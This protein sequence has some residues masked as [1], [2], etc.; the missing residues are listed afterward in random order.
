MGVMDFVKAGV[1]QMMIARP[2]DKKHLVVWKWPDQNIPMMS[3]LTVDSDEVAVFFKNGACMGI[4]PGGQRHTLSTQNIP[5]LTNLVNQFTG[6]NVLIAE[7]FFVKVQPVRG[8]PVGGPIGEM[9]DPLTQEVVCPRMF[10]EMS[11]QVVDPARFIIGYTGQAAAAEDNDV[12]LDWVKGLF[13]MGVKTTLGEVCEG[14]GK[15]VLQ[16]VSL[17]TV[18]AQRFVAKCQPLEDIGVRI[19]QMGNF[20]INF[21]AD[22]KQRLVA[23]QGEVA[24]AQRQ[25]RIKKAEAEA[26][27]FELD[28]KFGQDQRYV[29][30][31]AGNYGNYMAG[32]A[33]VAGAQNESGG[34]AAVGAQMAAGVGMAGMMAQNYQQPQGPQFPAPGMQGPHGQQPMQPQ[35]PQA[36][37]PQA[38]A[39]GA[40]NACRKCNAQNGPGAKFC[41]ECGTP[42]A[43]PAPAQRFCTSCGSQ[44]MGTAKF[45][46]SC[47]TPFQQV[48]AAG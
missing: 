39:G 4:L 29:Q 26:R 31:L 21:S 22:D 9:I 12:I 30:Q 18:L 25:I 3:Q 2:D 28:Q 37:A 41:A 34:V 43:P 33:M 24:A 47:G 27:Q 20:N 19:H 5:F 14:E 23:A 40:P 16:V 36:M 15:S 10:G 8:L 7:V 11:V 1:R 13:M 32:Q 44:N 46:A 45:C 38:Q 6:G 35:P 42:M 17:T 48:A